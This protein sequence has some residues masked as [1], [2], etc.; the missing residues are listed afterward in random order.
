MHKWY[1][2][3]RRDFE[4]TRAGKAKETFLGVE[5]FVYRREIGS[6]VRVLNCMLRSVGSIR[7]QM[8]KRGNERDNWKVWHS[9]ECRRGKEMVMKALNKWTGGKT[10]KNR[11][12]LVKRKRQC[13]E[14]TGM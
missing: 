12:K 14:I 9:D 6:A 10:W 3:K 7:W 8:E 4:Q 13:K 5:Y 2:G 11:F 1:E